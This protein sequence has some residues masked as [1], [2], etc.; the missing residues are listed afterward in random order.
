MAIDYRQARLRM[1]EQQLCPREITDARVL[2]AFRDVPRHRFVESAL[3]AQAYTDRAL[4]ISHGQTI[5]QPYM[6]AVMTQYLAP[7][8]EDR[9]L[10]IGTGS[11]YQAAILSR[12]ARTVYTVERIPD[13]AEQ[14]RLV[15][16]ELGI[17]NVVQHIGD[18]SLGRPDHAPYN[19]IIVTAGAPCVPQ[20]LRDQLADDGRLVVPTGSR[21][22]QMLRILRRAGEEFLEEAAVPCI[23]VPLMGEEGW[24]GE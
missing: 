15:L 19:G 8:S 20:S 23:F 2:Q 3:E 14:A 21:S 6:V 13:L 18:G 10:E 17:S 11:G 5:S 9:V 4:P 7:G 24:G 1:V 16:A 22:S 12:L